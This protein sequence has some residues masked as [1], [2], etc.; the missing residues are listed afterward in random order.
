MNKAIY[1]DMSILDNSK[2]IMYKFC[3]ITL[4]QS[5]GIK[6]N[7][8]DMSDTDSFIFHIITEEFLMMLSHG[9]THLIMMKMITELFQ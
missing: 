7:Y 3:M 5:I 9:M 6:Q 2:M 8:V 4:N 1:L